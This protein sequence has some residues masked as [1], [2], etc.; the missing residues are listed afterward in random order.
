MFAPTSTPVDALANANSPILL[1]S[2]AKCFF[3]FFFQ[4]A[5]W[6]RLK[7][8]NFILFF[9]KSGERVAFI[10]VIY[11][12]FIPAWGICDMNEHSREL[13]YI[14]CFR[15]FLGL[16]IPGCSQFC[17]ICDQNKLWYS[18]AFLVHS[19][20]RRHSWSIEDADVDKCW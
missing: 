6:I 11:E 2:L 3:F 20:C 14:W 10:N 15:L 13:C 12:F 8:Y 4:T 17:F 16:V 7:F 19:I 18:K 5:S 1:L 9:D